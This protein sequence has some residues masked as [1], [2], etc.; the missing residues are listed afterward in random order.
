MLKN[1]KKGRLYYRMSFKFAKKDLR[2][3]AM[4]RG[5]YVTRRYEAAD[6]GSVND[7]VLHQ[8][9]NDG[10]EYV[11]KVG[12]RIKVIVKFRVVSARNHVALVDYLPA[13]ME[14]LNS[15]VAGTQ[16]QGLNRQVDDPYVQ[17][18]NFWNWYWGSRTWWDHENLRDERAEAFSSYVPPGEYSYAYFVRATSEGTFIAPPAKAEE[19]YAPEVYGRSDSC[20]VVIHK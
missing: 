18:G 6:S 13:G 19:M 10:T 20:R 11:V 7:V 14:I 8:T 1:G 17:Q 2:T 4:D 9:E 5:F 12:T 15:K 16:T 3:D